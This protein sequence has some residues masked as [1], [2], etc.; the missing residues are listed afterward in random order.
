MNI[1]QILIAVSI[2]TMFAACSSDETIDTSQ[3]K[4]IKFNLAM[5]GT[6]PSTRVTGP[7][8][9]DNSF[10]D[11]TEVTVSTVESSIPI[12]TVQM[13][14]SSGSWSNTG[15]SKLYYPLNG[16]DAQIYAV[17]PKVD[18]IRNVFTNGFT[19]QSNQE[20]STNYLKSD[21]LFAKLSQAPSESAITIPMKHLCA[22]IV[23]TLDEEGAPD[24]SFYAKYS[25]VKISNVNM[26][27]TPSVT[28][29]FPGDSN[30]GSVELGTA[31]IASNVGVIPAQTVSSGTVLF[32]VSDGTN[33]YK[34]TTSSSIEFKSG[35][36]Y[37]FRLKI[38]RSE[39]TLSSLTLSGWTSGGSNSWDL[40]K[41]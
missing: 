16:S 19:V 28:G 32:E 4:E 18:D 22:R 8:S 33:T 25:S 10:A 27:G 15:T 34:Y 31:N 13:K 6:V 24:P 11:G 35:Y 7:N 21:L 26:T 41:V 30:K 1:K 36:S 2:G 23:I 12:S 14:Y 29:T 3:R 40:E 17:S 9:P 37:S 20:S 39:L 38:T 5:E